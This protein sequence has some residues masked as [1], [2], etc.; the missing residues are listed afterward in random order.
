MPVCLWLSLKA[1]I[2]DF[3]EFTQGLQ[4]EGVSGLNGL[5]VRV[6]VTQQGC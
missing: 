5:N 6:S 4:N 1:P 2:V 3:I